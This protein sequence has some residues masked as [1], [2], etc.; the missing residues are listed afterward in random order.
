MNNQSVDEYDIDLSWSENPEEKLFETEIGEEDDGKKGFFVPIIK[1][2]SM[3]ILVMAVLIFVGVAWFSMNGDVGTNG[4]EIKVK[5]S[6]FELRTAGS[7]GLYDNYITIADDEYTSDSETGASEKIIWKLTSD[8]QMQNL[9]SGSGEP[10]SED[11]RKIKKIDSSAYG[12]S[13]GDKG[14]LT[15]TIVPK[16]SESFDVKINTAMTCYRTDYDSSGYQTDTFTKMVST[17]VDDELS[18]KLIQGHIKYFYKADLDN[19][20][21]EEMHLITDDGFTVENISASTNVTIYWLWPENL[22]D[23][24][25]KTVPGLDETGA[26]ELRRCFFTDPEQFLQ[27]KNDSDSFAD[28]TLSEDATEAQIEAKVA[29]MTSTKQIYN[30]YSS[31][32]NN[33]DQTIGDN[34]GYIMFE[35]MAE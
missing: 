4:M 10:T 23:I 27:K 19:D 34:V 26:A 22:R 5:A 8:S 7:T 29:M 11:I 9:W 1:S 35:A 25:E 24:L 21:L 15:F 18:L 2:F 16:I 14:E 28:I 13:P 20:N 12:L 17:N 6:T 31:R 30:S 3:M 32:Y 33:A